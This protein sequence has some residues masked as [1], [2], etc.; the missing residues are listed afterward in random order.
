MTAHIL[1]RHSCPIHYWLHEDASL[2][3]VV[4]TH[5]AGCDHKMFDAQLP[6]LD[7][8]YRVLTWDVRGHGLSRPIG[9]A[10]F[11][12]DLVAEDLAAILDDARVTAEKIHAIPQLNDWLGDRLLEGR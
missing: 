12:L 8:K 9:D 7:G 4:L 6:A 5:G 10:S 11:T 1:D 2:P 3:T